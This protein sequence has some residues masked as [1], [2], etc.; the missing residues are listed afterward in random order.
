MAK[1][2]VDLSG[3]C[4]FAALAFVLLALPNIASAQDDAL[5]D[6]EVGSKRIGGP[7]TSNERKADAAWNAAVE[8]EETPMTEE[9]LPPKGDKKRLP[10]LHKL[11]RQYFGGRMWKE[12]CEKF[13]QIVE[14][15]GGNQALDL[16]PEAKK[17]AARSYFECGQLAFNTAELDHVERWLKKSEQLGPSEERHRLLRRK[18]LRESYRKLMSNG[19]VVSALTTFKQYQGGS[20][21]EDERIWMGE[22]LAKL[23]WAS[24]QSKDKVSMRDYIRYGDEVAPMNT[25]LRKLK[26]KLASEEGVI[27]NVL[28]FGGA[29]IALVIGATQLSKW[30]ARAKVRK[31]AGSD[32]DD[33]DDISEGEEA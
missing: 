15:G 5:Q 32:F 14:E 4:A 11:A 30:R 28:M 9:T 7:G 3:I 20:P 13:D 23:A 10:A 18:V 24:Y 27:P 8:E 16:V 31:L 1:C 19:D 26:D 22:Q 17:N 2:A 12:S 25:E 33:N 29:A 21:D 6:I